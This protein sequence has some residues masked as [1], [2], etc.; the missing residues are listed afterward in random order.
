MGK[1]TIDKLNVRRVQ[2]KLDWALGDVD[3]VN[4]A[5]VNQ[6]VDNVLDSAQAEGRLNSLE[7]IEV[8]RYLEEVW[9]ISG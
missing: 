4:K 7:R 1:L 5:I 9:G 2:D 6:I 3:L 8:C